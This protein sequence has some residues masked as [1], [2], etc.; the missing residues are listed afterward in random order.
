MPRSEPIRAV[1]GVRDILPAEMPVWRAAQAGAAA[2]AR[3]F[4]YE[5]IVTP[6][7]EL[8]GDWLHEVGL[9]DL[10]LELNT[11]GD[12][13]CRPA[14]LERLKRYYRPLKSQLG[15]DSQ[16]RLERNPLRLLDSKVPQEQPFKDGAPKIID[17]L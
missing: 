5:E 17:H 10:R 8:A 11:I 7:I 12:A 9:Q 2:V 3:R 14:Y 13:K 16:L 15:G 1:R 4:G 6:I